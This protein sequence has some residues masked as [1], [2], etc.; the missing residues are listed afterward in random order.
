MQVLTIQNKI[1][2]IPEDDWSSIMKQLWC[3]PARRSSSSNND[4]TNYKLPEKKIKKGKQKMGSL[5]VFKYW[6]ICDSSLKLHSL[7]L[8]SCNWNLILLWTLWYQSA[9]GYRAITQRPFLGVGCASG[10][11]Q[12]TH[13][14]A[15]TKFWPKMEPIPAIENGCRFW[16]CWQNLWLICLK[17]WWIWQ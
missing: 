17:C 1:N 15:F 6:Q 2:S 9:W 5:R 14:L 3:C 16:E 10:K 11:W 4:T 7:L 12:M 13:P 8:S